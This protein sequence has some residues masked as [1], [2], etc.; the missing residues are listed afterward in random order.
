MVIIKEFLVFI[1]IRWIKTGS[2]PSE[3]TMSSIVLY[4]AFYSYNCTFLYPRKDVYNTMREIT[5]KIWRF[6]VKYWT[7]FYKAAT[8]VFF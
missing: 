2:Y 5:I 1:R 3:K 7:I 8:Q 6:L 4:P